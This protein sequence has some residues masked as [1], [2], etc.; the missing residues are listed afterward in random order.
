MRAWGNAKA[1]GDITRVQHK[2]WGVQGIQANFVFFFAL[3]ADLTVIVWGKTTAIYKRKVPVVS[4]VTDENY[5]VTSNTA[6]F[7]VR[8]YC[9]QGG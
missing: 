7:C 4:A 6:A 2:L 5:D 3:R 9:Q 8:S 1:G